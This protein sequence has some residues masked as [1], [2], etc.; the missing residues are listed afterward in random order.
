[1]TEVAQG[2]RALDAKVGGVFDGLENN[3]AFVSA[4]LHAYQA[5]LR[6]HQDE[7]RRA[8]KNAVLNSARSDAL[9][10]DVQLTFVRFLD[11]LTPSHITLLQRF[12]EH[13]AELRETDSYQTLFDVLAT[14]IGGVAVT[15]EE[16]KLLCSDLQNRVLL[17][18]SPSVE[19][20]HDIHHFDIVITEQGRSEPPPPKVR[21]T[22]LGKRFLA[23]AAE[24]ADVAT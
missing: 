2:L 13:E 20:F 6:S 4:F 12:L 8:L 18:I 7:K 9:G 14:D 10:V 19:D 11:E 15:T 23:F 22:D 3:E 24:P 1:M 16:F 21:V 17:R 5:A